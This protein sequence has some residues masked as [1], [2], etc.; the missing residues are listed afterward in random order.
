MKAFLVVVLI[1]VIAFILF[2]AIGT[3][4]S[5][6]YSIPYEEWVQV[7]QEKAEAKRHK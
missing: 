6:Y 2:V 1:A 3:Y 4:M 7:E 5:C